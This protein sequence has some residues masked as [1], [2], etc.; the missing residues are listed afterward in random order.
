MVIIYY[1]CEGGGHTHNGGMLK[2][3]T[4]ADFIQP[5]HYQDGWVFSHNVTKVWYAHLVWY[6]QLVLAFTRTTRKPPKTTQTEA[7]CFL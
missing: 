4:T 6:V 3:E 5:S 2:T 7:Q 1:T